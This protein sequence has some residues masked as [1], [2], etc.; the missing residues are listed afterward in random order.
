MGIIGWLVLG[1][2]AG[3]IAKFI[4]RGAEPGGVVG[5]LAIGV[6]GALLGGFIA[7]ALG[8]G[9]IDSFFSIG[10]WIIA[11]LGALLLLAVYNTLLGRRAGRSARPIA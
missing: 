5:T 2:V 3:I 7:S 8:V 9:S 11:I 1:L 10:T 4:H 6:V